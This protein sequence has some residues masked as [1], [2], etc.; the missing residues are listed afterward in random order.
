MRELLPDNI[1]LAV[2]LEALPAATRGNN[3]PQREIASVKTW[4]CAFTTYIVIVAQAHPARV[5][6]MLAYMRLIIREAQKYKEGV[7]WMTYDSVFRQ[8]HQGMDA[9]WDKL[10]PSLH[11]TYIGGQGVPTAPPCRH[12]RGVDH[13]SSSCALSPLTPPV[14]SGNPP[15]FES[16][17]SE[18][19]ARQSNLRQA[20]IFI[21]RSWNSGKCRFPGTCYYRHMCATCDKNHMAK[22][23]K[24]LMMDSSRQ[25]QTH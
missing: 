5:C 3:I 10:D 21:C 23:C 20:G 7:G 6:D 1:A 12:C 19:R 22:D 2:R 18:R 11:T 4:T 14:Q 25:R 8:N 24:R 17:A 15:Q 13:S 9:R 16:P